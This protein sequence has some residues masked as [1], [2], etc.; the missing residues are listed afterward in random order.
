MHDHHALLGA[1]ADALP[2]QQ[3]GGIGIVELRQARLDRLARGHYGAGARLDQRAQPRVERQG[4]GE[5]CG[6][7]SDQ[8]DAVAGAMRRPDLLR[9]RR[10]RAAREAEVA[11]Q[12]DVEAMQGWRPP[13]R[14]WSRATVLAVPARRFGHE[15]L[16]RSVRSRRGRQSRSSP[17]PH[18]AGGGTAGRPGRQLPPLRRGRRSRGPGDPGLAGLCGAAAAAAA[19]GGAGQELPRLLSGRPLHGR[20]DR[21]HG[22]DAA[23][24]GDRDRRGMGPAGVDD[25]GGRAGAGGGLGQP[26]DPRG[27]RP[28]PSRHAGAPRRHGPIAATGLG[29]PA[30]GR[31]AAALGGELD[32]LARRRSLPLQRL[33][34]RR[35]RRGAA[36]RGAARPA[37]AL[38]PPRPALRHR[39]A[40]GDQ[41]DLPAALLHLLPEP[42]HPG[43]Q[44]QRDRH[45]A[46]V[47]R[48]DHEGRQRLSLALSRLRHRGDHG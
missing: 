19:G 23:G 42:R 7:Q 24:Q 31:H 17:R 46:A 37:R 2:R 27:R 22:A 10:R 35:P 14:L 9:H 6:L 11:Q 39:G 32:H 21:I 30:A 47:G 16:R 28:V 26:L 18:G 29:R 4:S 41:A 40:A 13:G 25:R 34:L 15:R 43:R 44:R 8:T 33:E 20:A 48:R 5:V 12:H 45:V 1:Q 3:H 38:S 36:P